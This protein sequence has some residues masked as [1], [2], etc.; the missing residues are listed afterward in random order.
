VDRE[1]CLRN[2]AA[3]TAQT[4]DWAGTWRSGS[5]DDFIRTRRGLT[6]TITDRTGFGV[7]LNAG[8]P[9]GSRAPSN[10]VEFEFTGE[11]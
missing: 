11:A 7:S 3:M 2:Y 4:T 6:L 9:K 8:L 1:G 5:I 10:N